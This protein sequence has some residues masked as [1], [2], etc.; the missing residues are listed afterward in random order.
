MMPHRVTSPTKD[1]W[2]V[3]RGAAG[4][5]RTLDADGRTSA[6][7]GRQKAIL[8]TAADLFDDRGFYQTSM[9]DVAAAVNLKKP[10]LYHYFKSKDEL[11]YWIHDD[12]ITTL[13]TSLAARRESDTDPAHLLRGVMVDIISFTE[14]NHGYLRTF[15]E[16]LR[17]LPPKFQTRIAVKREAY[18]LEVRELVEACAP[19]SRTQQEI[20]LLTLGILGTC[21]WTYQWYRS[22]RRSMRGPVATDQALVDDVPAEQVADLFWR[23]WMAGLGA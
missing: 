7:R 5:P 18:A 21:N 15:F 16:N 17:D 11:L 19:S 23:A 9:D 10:S 6:A 14:N 13:E 8:R 2:M 4:G 22:G 12:Y 1:A 20:A 3:A